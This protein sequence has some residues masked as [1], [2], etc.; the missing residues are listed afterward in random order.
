MLVDGACSGV[1]AELPGR[2]LWAAL[3]MEDSVCLFAGVYMHDRTRSL[4]LCDVSVF[5][6]GPAGTTPLPRGF[7]NT[8]CE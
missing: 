7:P 1:S 2:G 8:A 4:F 5:P 3:L 6:K